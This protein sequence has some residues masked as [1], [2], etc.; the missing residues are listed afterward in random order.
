MGFVI[1]RRDQQM[2]NDILLTRDYGD[3]KKGFKAFSNYGKKAI[4]FLQD[5]RSTEANEDVKN[6]IFDAILK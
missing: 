1:K 5:L 3:R 4:P 6:Y 2:K